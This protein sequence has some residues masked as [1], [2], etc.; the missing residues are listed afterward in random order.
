MLKTGFGHLSFRV[1]RHGLFSG[2]RKAFVEAVT[3]ARAASLEIWSEDVTNTGFEVEGL[4]LISDRH[5]I[6]P[7]LFRRLAEYL[8]GGGSIEGFKQFLE[9]KAEDIAVISTAHFTHVDTI[10]EVDGN[11]NRVSMTE[12]PENIVFAG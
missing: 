5:M 3:R 7:K 4:E 9:Q 2:L 8:E 6:M 10:V 11:G 12:R 1:V